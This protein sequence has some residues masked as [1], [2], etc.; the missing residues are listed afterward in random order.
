MVLARDVGYI[1]PRTA[2]VGGVFHLTDGYHPSFAE[3]ERALAAALQREVPMR[4]PLGVAKLGAQVGDKVQRMT[5]LKMP[6][7]IR[8]LMKMTSTLTFSD[9]RAQKELGWNPSRVLDY[10]AELVR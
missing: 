6:L 9:M 5:G 3:L 7:T 2:Q 10:A 4:L 1:L 8:S